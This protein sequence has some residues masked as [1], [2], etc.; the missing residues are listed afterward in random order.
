MWFILPLQVLS[1]CLGIIHCSLIICYGP[2]MC[3]VEVNILTVP[4][5][6]SGAR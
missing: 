2:G 4:G 5:I 6:Y 1:L 3:E